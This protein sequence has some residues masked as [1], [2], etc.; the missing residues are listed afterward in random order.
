MQRISAFG[1][2][3]L[4]IFALGLAAW[5]HA[6][7]G[8]M[9]SQPPPRQEPGSQLMDVSAARRS[10]ELDTTIPKLVGAMG[11]SKEVRAKVA[12]PLAAENAPPFPLTPVAAGLTP[13]GLERWS[14]LADAAVAAN[15]RYGRG[16]KAKPRP[17]VTVMHKSRIVRI[18][19]TYPAP[20]AS[21]NLEP[22]PLTID[23]WVC[24]DRPTALALF[25]LRNWGL[26]RLDPSTSE[27][28][29]KSLLKAD[30]FCTA[31]KAREGDPGESAYWYFP[32][33]AVSVI[34]PKGHKP[35]YPDRFSF[36]RGNV[37][38]EASTVEFTWEEE[39]KDWLAFQLTVCAPDIVAVMR[40]IDAGLLRLD[41]R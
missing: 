30:A 33:L 27:A 34:L 1:L 21:K 39:S 19:A 3:P 11:A 22:G 38:V 2:L 25:W 24:P 5:S 14:A 35:L 7:C 18:E 4:V 9:P 41:R 8:G 23:A 26:G 32:R 31:T 17:T 36:L 10:K 16:G 6:G 20:V 28:V 15:P 12:G 37:V 40:S 13:G 29:A